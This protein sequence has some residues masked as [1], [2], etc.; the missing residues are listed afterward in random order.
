M[1][2]FAGVAPFAFRGPKVLRFGSGEVASV[3]AEAARLGARALIVTGRSSAAASG[4]LE[5][6]TASLEAAG[7]AWGVYAGTPPEPRLE[8]VERG[9]VALRESGA[10]LVVALGGGSAL[11]VGKAIAA[12]GRRSEPVSDFHG[13]GA[14][15]ALGL[16]CIALPTTSGTGAEVTPNSVLTD[17]E[18]GVKTSIRGDGLLPEVAIVDPALTLSLP[19]APT[20][21]SG[22]DAL[23]Q[24]MEAYVSIAAN[25]L[26]DAWALLACERIAG[27]L[28]RAFAQGDD[29]AAREALALGS[30]LAG[31]ALGSARLGLVHGLAH[32]IGTLTGKPHGLLCGS[33]LAPV[34]RANAEA[35]AGRY[36]RIAAAVGCGGGAESLADWV[37]DLCDRLGVPTRLEGLGV[38]EDDLAEI[39]RLSATA[40]STR[41]NPRQVT[42]EELL[43][44]LRGWM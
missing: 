30:V 31:Y 14:L 34:I 32:P 1:G 23:C 25:P 42:P 18:R 12:L 36:E 27:S 29:L 3:G 21:H 17:P 9:R 19:P 35:A 24:A 16:P 43:G 44:L 4:G 11:D 40:G 20:A 39:A 5:Q 2:A 38:A 37:A 41:F 26:S 7:C 33:L 28:A 6:V 10:D 13:R 15:D 22:L 8:D